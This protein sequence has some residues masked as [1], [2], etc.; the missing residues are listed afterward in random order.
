MTLISIWDA[1]V[2]LYFKMGEQR[3]GL[4][5]QKSGRSPYKF[6]ALQCI[7]KGARPTILHL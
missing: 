6:G 2:T 7:D 1:M 5:V 3:T 4:T